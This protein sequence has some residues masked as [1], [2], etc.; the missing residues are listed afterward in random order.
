ML[1][2]SQDEKTFVILENVGQIYIY[3]SNRVIESMMQSECMK[4][5]D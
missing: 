1:I 4:E 5:V 3:N 2:V